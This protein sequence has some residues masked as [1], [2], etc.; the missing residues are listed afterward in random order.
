[1]QLQYRALHY[2]A[3]RSKNQASLSNIWLIKNFHSN[4]TDI[5]I[6]LTQMW[7]WQFY[8]DLHCK[9][10]F[11]FSCFQGHDTIGWVAGQEPCHM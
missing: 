7:V 8:N 6:S 2:S 5:K 9:T 3:L 1:M 10:K 11:L 4:K